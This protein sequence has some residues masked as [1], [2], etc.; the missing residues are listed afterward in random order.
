MISVSRHRVRAT[1]ME[2]SHKIKP[3]EKN[4]TALTIPKMIAPPNTMVIQTTAKKLSFA[5][6]DINIGIKGIENY[7]WKGPDGRGGFGFYTGGT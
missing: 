5:P 1:K 4:R 3:K 2:K 7:G 6:K